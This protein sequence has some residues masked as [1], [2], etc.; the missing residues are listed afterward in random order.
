[1]QYAKDYDIMLLTHHSLTSNGTEATAL[2]D[3]FKHYK[4]GFAGNE[5]SLH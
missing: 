2:M 5:R 4:W 1:M 3:G